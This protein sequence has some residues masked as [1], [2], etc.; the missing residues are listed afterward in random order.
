M[1][2]DDTLAA[3]SSFDKVVGGKL[4]F[5][6]SESLSGKSKKE[7][8]RK[9]TS[10]VAGGDKDPNIEAGKHEDKEEEEEGTVKKSEGGEDGATEIDTG[11]GFAPDGKKKTKKYEELFPFETERFG[12]VVPTAVETREAALDQ[13]VKKKADRYCK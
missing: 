3:M 1:E 11:T 12:Y 10:T 7:K 4:K 5:K 2:G 9:K 13:R 8:K 6:G